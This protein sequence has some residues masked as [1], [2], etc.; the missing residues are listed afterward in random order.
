MMRQ[1]VIKTT[2]ITKLPHDVQATVVTVF[3]LMD[4]AAGGQGTV[5]DAISFDAKIDANKI[6]EAMKG[7]STNKTALWNIICHRSNAQ[8]LEI[9]VAF[10][11]M[12]GKDLLKELFSE[13]SGNF[14]TVITALM[15]PPADYD[16]YELH[17]AMS[18]LGTDEGT[19]IEVL[20]SRT[21]AQIRLINESYLRMYGKLLEAAIRDDT[22]GKLKRI[23]VALCTAGRS[24]DYVIDRVKAVNQ[25]RD[26][27]EAGVAKWSTDDSTFNAILCAENYAQLQLVFVEYQKL[28]HHDIE[29]AIKKEFSGDA[30]KGLLAIVKCIKNKPA[31]FAERLHHAMSGLGTKDRTLIRVIVS[32]S[33]IDMVQIKHE[34]FRMY[35]K[36]LEEFIEADTSGKYEDA[37]LALI[38]MK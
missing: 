14:E 11:S 10:K 23:L 17:H 20:C 12:F 25:A 36:T 32:R 2:T 8:R 18:G 4:P 3:P 30:Q 21:P 31:Y 33:E 26:L 13:L 22:S 1:E 5:R 28:A 35:G 27:Y 16:A 34:F 6:H 19:L 24:E 9:A 15:F 37:L 7:F 38:G 29:D